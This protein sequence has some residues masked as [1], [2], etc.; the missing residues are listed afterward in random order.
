MAPPYEEQK[1]LLFTQHRILLGIFSL[2]NIS[3]FE[4]SE[5]NLQRENE[6]YTIYVIDKHTIEEENHFPFR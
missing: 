1:K 2:V 4:L 5:K 6:K 3:T